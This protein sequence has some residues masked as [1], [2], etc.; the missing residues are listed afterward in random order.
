MPFSVLFMLLQPQTDTSSMFNSTTYQ[1]LSPHVVADPRIV[2]TYIT[3][4]RVTVIVP[5]SE[6]TTLRSRS[7]ICS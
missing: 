2:V 4:K 3:Q 5:M 7:L 1:H 6:T